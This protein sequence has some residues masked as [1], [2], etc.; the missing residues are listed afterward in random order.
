MFASMIKPGL[1]NTLQV[2][3]VHDGVAGFGD[4]L[5]IPVKELPHTAQKGDTVSLFVYP[6]TT[7]RFALSASGPKALVGELA[8]LKVKSIEISGAWLDW[9]FSQLLF[10]PRGFHEDDLQVGDQ[11][12]VKVIYDAKTNKILGKEKLEDEYSNTELTVKEKEVVDLVIYRDTPIGYQV[13]INNKHLGLLHNNEAFGDYYAGDKLTGFIKKIKPGNL[14]DVVTGKPGI[15]RTDVHTDNILNRLKQSNGF[16]PFTD[17]TD[18]EII[19]RE[20]AMSKK[21]FKMV[22]GRLYQQR[23]ISIESDGIRLVQRSR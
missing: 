13:I 8:V 1:F 16:M 19:Y 7:G 15:S 12:L 23:K 3:E 5:H 22:I 9:G 14:L 4:S 2:Q 20:F 11:C 21:T 6:D 17:K 18:P 10:V